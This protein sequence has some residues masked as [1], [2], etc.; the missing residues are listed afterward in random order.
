[1][2]LGQGERNDL[3]LQYSPTIINL[4]S[5]LHYQLSGHRP[6]KFLK[7]PQFSLFPI[8]KP[9][10][11][12]LTLPLNRSRVFIC[13]NYDGLESPML[14]AKFLEIGPPILEKKIF[15]GLLPYMD[16]AAILVM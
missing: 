10:L 2:A 6:Q 7:N 9:K 12:N 5:C 4:I 13:T 14:H 3:D 1:M 8:E 11:P 16:V 15:E